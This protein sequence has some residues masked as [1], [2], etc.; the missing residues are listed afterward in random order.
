MQVVG[1]IPARYNSRRLSHKLLRKIAG[2]YLLQRT[3]ERASLAKKLDKLIIACDNIKIERK[4]KSWGAEVV[5]TSPH[6]TSGT[7]RIAEVARNIKAKIIINIQA[8]EPFISP[9]LI[10]KLA[11]LMLEEKNIA[12]STAK[13]KIKDENELHNPNIV[14]VVCD[15]NNF[16]L[17]FSRYPIPYIRQKMRLRHYRHIGIY[18]YKREV[19]EYFVKLQPPELERSEKLEQLRLL[20]Y[21][22]KIKVIETNSFSLGIDTEEDL[23]K[24]ELLL[25]QKT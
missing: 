24:A 12:V 7:D 9:H 22:Y 16:A 4:A 21:G 3:W 10:D 2:K 23:K 14:K 25:Q 1:V 19:L 17:Y 13:T 18:A 6:H 11:S 8:D 15:K 5:L 20:Y